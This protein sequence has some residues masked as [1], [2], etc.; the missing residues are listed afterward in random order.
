MKPNHPGARPPLRRVAAAARLAAVFGLGSLNALGAGAQEAA[1]ATSGPAAA[2]PALPSVTVTAAA[3]S[4]QHL[5]QRVSSGVLGSRSQLDTPFS[6]TV[7][8]AEELADRQVNK[9]GDVFALDASVS[10]NSDAYS[11]WSSYL[12]VRGLQLDWQNGFKI[13]G[14]PYIGY[15]ITMPYDHFERVE[16]LKGLSGFMYGFGTPGGVVNYVTKKPTDTPVRSID[17]GFRSSGIWSEHVDLGGRFG[18]DQM[19][20]YRFNAT[21]EEGQ[22]RNA[23]SINRDTLSLAL[24]ARLTR[25]LTWTFETTYQKRRALGQLPSIYTASYTGTSLPATISGARGSLSGNDQHLYTNLQLYTTGLRYQLAPDWTLSTTYSFSKASRSRNEST[26]YLT[27]A[28]G[29]YSDY[30]YDGTQSHQFAFWQTMAEGRVRTGPFTHQLVFGTS[31]QRQINRYSS[32]SVFQLLG[33]GNLYQA[34]PFRYDST[35][36]YTQQRNGDIDQRSLFASD[37]IQLSE[38]WSVLGGLRYTRYQQNNYDGSGAISSSYNRNG[39]VTP[40]VALMFKPLP[41]TT[42]YGSYVESL[43][44]GG[45]APLTTLNAGQMLGPLKSRQYE[46][47]VKTEQARWS[48]TAALFRIERGAE[49]TNSQNVYVQDGQSIYQGLELAGTTRLGTQWELGGSL[50]V[51]DSWYAKGSAYDGNRVA[52]A[53]R[54]VAAARLGYRVPFVPGLR[55]GVDGKFTGSTQL[56]QANNLSVPGYMVF[57]LGASYTTRLSG[58]DVTLR[59]AVNNLADRRYWEFQ[60][61]DYIKPGDPRSVSL[62]AKIDF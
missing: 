1:P 49:Y 42:L 56:R 34:N 37:T 26:L 22:A 18:P 31:W 12:T 44:Q 15:G 13:D 21:H 7:V 62:N 30:R 55:V 24:D 38:R 32:T 51:L 48:A 11:A 6:T 58:Y 50:M 3:D 17:V 61:A 16:L 10:D 35:N 19:F 57:N 39:V 2:E 14:L 45:E 46:V 43:E 52:G 8:D 20:G 60:Y 41:S 33:T 23:G 36:T 53:P 5:E 40:T 4:P 27:D 54:V 9:L 47:G 59:A 28:A 29:D 25:D